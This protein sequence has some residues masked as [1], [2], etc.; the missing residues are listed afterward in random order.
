MGGEG[1][2]L[3]IER[4]QAIKKSQLAVKESTEVSPK[5]LFNSENRMFCKF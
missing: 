5:G 1:N 2:E 3:E 4:D